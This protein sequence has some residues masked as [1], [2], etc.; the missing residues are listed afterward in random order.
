VRAGRPVAIEGS[1][2]TVMAGLSAGEVSILA[3]ELLKP[4]VDD[5]MT[6]ED[7]AVGEL[8]RILARGEGSDPPLVAGESGVA[9]LAGALAACADP[10]LSAALGLDGR[11]SVL[12]FGTEGA[13]DPDVYRAIVGRAPEE[14]APA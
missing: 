7:A 3:W 14:V 9:G 1:L 10:D 5:V 12:V 4:G 2:E 13:T 8:M 6:V 11:A